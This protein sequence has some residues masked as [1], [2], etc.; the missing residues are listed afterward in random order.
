MLPFQPII[1]PE[2]QILSYTRSRRDLQPDCASHQEEHDRRAR[3][4][5]FDE[6]RGS[7]C[8]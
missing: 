5:G 4:A 1:H 2:K 8:R 3:S 6:T 7:A